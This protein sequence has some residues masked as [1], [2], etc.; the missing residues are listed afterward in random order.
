MNES[1]KSMLKSYIRGF[2]TAI[3]PLIVIGE[4][5]WKTIVLAGLAAVIPPAIRALDKNDPA[6]GIIASVIETE[7]KKVA[8]KSPVKKVVKKPLS[9]KKTK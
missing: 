3:T 6:F 7:L 9:I 5:D 4:M 1:I 8:K 2:I